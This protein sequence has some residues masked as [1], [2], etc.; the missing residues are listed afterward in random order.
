MNRIDKGCCG[1]CAK[2][3]LLANGEVDMVPCALDQILHR[4]MRLE[5]LAENKEAGLAAAECETK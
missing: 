1:D 4:V 5:R 3:V 2:C